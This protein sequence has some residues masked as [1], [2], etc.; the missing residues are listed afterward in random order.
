MDLKEKETLQ[1]HEL[2]LSDRAHLSL[3]GVKEVESFDENVIVLSTAGGV[4]IVR[5]EKLQLRA[6]SVDGGQVSVHG[7]ID[8]L[9]YEAP[10]APG[11]FFKRIFS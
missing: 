11:G 4:L 5:G 3:S 6:L 1:P 10:K 8:S 9:S 2:R 7:L